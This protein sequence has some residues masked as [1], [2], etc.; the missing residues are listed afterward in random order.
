MPKLVPFEEIVAKI[1]KEGNNEYSVLTV[2]EKYV[3]TY[4]KISLL[5]SICGNIYDVTP[6]K[7][8]MNRRCPLCFG[9]KKKTNEQVQKEI[10]LSSSVG[11]YTLVGDYL[12]CNENITLL[13]AKC[14]KNFLVQT[15][16]FLI[17]GNRCPFCVKLDLMSTGEKLIRKILNDL[18]LSFLQDASFTDLYTSTTNNRKFYLE[19]DFYIEKLNLLI[20]FDGNQ[21]N[22]PY[23]GRN[24]EYSTK[25]FNN[26]VINDQRKNNYCIENK[27]NFV[28]F[29]YTE[30]SYKKNLNTL[31]TVISL[32]A[33]GYEVQ[34]L[35]RGGMYIDGKSMETRDISLLLLRD[36]DIV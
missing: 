34:R 11:E 4:T 23:K 36:S 3:N 10:D 22:I 6:T 12:S 16:N 2:K 20:E 29:R 14:G 8:F 30:K 19:F 32:I 26:L 24:T 1:K 7:F 5:H 13:H 31:Q 33:K 15:N 18:K 35:I 21:H 28:R 9:S 27:V 17:R 25:K